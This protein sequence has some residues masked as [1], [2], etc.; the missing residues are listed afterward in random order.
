[1]EEELFLEESVLEEAVL[2]EFSAVSVLPDE[3]AV[4]AKFKIVTEVT[5][6]FLP[7]TIFTTSPLARLET[8]P[9]LPL[10]SFTVV[11]EVSVSSAVL[12]P[13]LNVYVVTD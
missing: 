9:L 8:F 3:G 4:F 1:M 10:A 11:L 13:A 12:L 6:L 2:F 7:T 5:A